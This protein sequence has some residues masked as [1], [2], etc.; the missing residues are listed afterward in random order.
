MDAFFSDLAGTAL[1][2]ETCVARILLSFLAG[3]IMGLERKFRMRFV[4]IRTLVLICVS[5]CVIMLLSIYLSQVLFDGSGDPARLAA[6]VVSGIGFLGGGAIL[7]EGFNV[8]GLTSA[9]I[10]WTAAALGLTI[11]AGFLLPALVALLISLVTLV[12]IELLE[13]HFFPAEDLKILF[14]TC[15]AIPPEP[16]SLKRIASRFGVV[17]TSLSSASSCD[18]SLLEVSYEVRITKYVDFQSLATQLR[19]DF[20]I[21]D[22]EL[23]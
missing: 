15:A 3:C 6:Q 9:A 16:K 14:L 19:H 4:G 23:R 10:I 2:W 11:G 1:P 13:E 17:V 5:S 21:V 22:I 7:R 20:D 8:K 18:N 12:L